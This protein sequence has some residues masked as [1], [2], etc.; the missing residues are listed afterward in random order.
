MQADSLPRIEKKKL[1][2]LTER[3]KVRQ[4]RVQSSINSQNNY[5]FHHQPIVLPVSR[6]GLQRKYFNY[7]NEKKTIESNI[8]NIIEYENVIN[9]EDEE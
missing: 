5:Q 1:N 9:H 3:Q 2:F 8:D 6:G 7:H 4:K